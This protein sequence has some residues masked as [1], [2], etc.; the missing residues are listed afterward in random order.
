MKYPIAFDPSRATIY[1]QDATERVTELHR[2]LE[3]LP[4]IQIIKE[5]IQNREMPDHLIEEAVNFMVISQIWVAM[6]NLKTG[7]RKKA[8]QLLNVCK[9]GTKYKTD[10][11]YLRIRATLPPKLVDFAVKIKLF[12]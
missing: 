7:N 5:A 11:L 2:L 3:Q 9:P 8:I 1:H 4:Y 12:S 6:E 10:W